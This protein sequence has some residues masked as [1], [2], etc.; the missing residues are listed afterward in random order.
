MDPKWKYG[1]IGALI[2]AILGTQTYLML[3]DDEPAPA[4]VPAATNRPE[5]TMAPAPS[6]DP[7]RPEAPSNAPSGKAS[8][9]PSPLE[10]D[11][12][13][14]DGHRHE[15]DSIPVE[16]PTDNEIR[17]DLTLVEKT[18]KAWSSKSY[19]DNTANAWTDRLAALATVEYGELMRTQ[20]P[21]TSVVIDDFRRGIVEPKATTRVGKISYKVTGGTENTG[22]LRVRAEYPVE[23]AYGKPAKAPVKARKGQWLKHTTVAYEFDYVVEDGAWRLYNVTA[24]TPAKG[25]DVP[26]GDQDH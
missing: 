25:T 14:A 21:L 15:S 11:H 1:A 23:I 19:T 9:A 8:Y 18:A 17:F 6:A 7:V 20:F 26:Y 10:A 16:L 22:W 13:D 12:D 2:V 4:P 3:R 5:V 24:T